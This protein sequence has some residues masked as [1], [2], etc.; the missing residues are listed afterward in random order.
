M[1]STDTIIIIIKFSLDSHVK[2]AVL[3]N[4]VLPGDCKKLD[5]FYLDG[6]AF[7]PSRHQIQMAH[8]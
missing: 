5:L 3:K 1:I 8:S 2:C 6:H 7:T 4:I